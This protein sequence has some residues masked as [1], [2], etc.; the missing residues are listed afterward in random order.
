MPRRSEKALPDVTND[1]F[2]AGLSA[3]A[4]KPKVTEADVSGILVRPCLKK[5]L[6]YDDSQIDAEPS[7]TQRLR[8]DYVC[9]G[10]SLG[11]ELIIEVK[12][13]GTN[14]DKRRSTSY[15]TSPTGQLTNYLQKREDAT[16]F[17]W[18]L[19]TNGKEWRLFRRKGR[20]IEYKGRTTPRTL[21]DL[22]KLLNA[23]L[24]TRPSSPIQIT[25]RDLPRL[26]LPV[27]SWLDELKQ[28]T[29]TPQGFVATV[30]PSGVVGGAIQQSTNTYSHFALAR[31]GTINDQNTL[32]GASVY[33]TA[34]RLNLPDNILAP[35][36]ITEA[37]FDA[38]QVCG[39]VLYGIAWIGQL[40]T[41]QCRGFLFENGTLRTTSSFHPDLPGSRAMHQ[42][43]QFEEYGHEDLDKVRRVLD[44]I[45]LR[46]IF[47]EEIS[48]WFKR[49]KS[50][51][52]ELRHLIRILF[53]WLLQVREII[54]DTALLPNNDVLND[55]GSEIHDHIEW[56][57]TKVLAKA[58]S[59]RLESGRDSDLAETV[60]F[61]NGSLF[62]ELNE[63]DR[64]ESLP[65]RL[66][67]AAGDRPGLLNILQRYDWTLSEQTGYESETAIDPSM[68]GT[69]F[70]R[71]MLTIEGPR[72]ES[73]GNIKMPGGTYYT[74]HDIA[75]EMTADAVSHWL[76]RRIPS[77]PLD[78]IRQL[79]HPAPAQRQWNSLDQSTRSLILEDLGTLTVFDPCCGS[80]AFTVSMLR[81]LHRASVRLL[82]QHQPNTSILDR[83]IERQLYACDIHPLAVL[84]TRL[85]LFIALVDVKTRH[86][87]HR[88]VIRPL[89]NLET[90]F[91]TANTLCIDVGKQASLNDDE[92]DRNL[93]DLR[94]ARELWITAYTNEEKQIS[95]SE[96]A[97]SRRSI[98]KLIK[99]WRPQED[100]A[101]LDLDLTSHTEKVASVDVRKLFV[102]S[103]GWDIIIGNPPYQ[104]PSIVDRDRAKRHGYVSGQANLY[105]LFLEAALEATK[106]DGCITMII[107]HS[108]V[109][110][111]QLVY[112]TTRQR[113][114][115]VSDCIRIRTYDNRPQPVF[116][117]LPWLK[118]NQTSDESRQR[119]TV[120][121]IEKGLSSKVQVFSKGLIRLTSRERSTILQVTKG[122]QEQPKTWRQWTQCPTEATAKLLAVMR[123]FEKRGRLSGKTRK[124]SFPP[125]AMYFISC[126]PEGL[127]NNRNRKPYLLPDDEYYWLW[128]GLYNSHLFHAYWLMLGD[129]FHVTAEEYST[130]KSPIGWLDDSMRHETEKLTKRLMTDSVLNAC[131]TVHSGAGGKKWP[132]VNFHSNSGRKIISDLDRVLI[133]AYGLAVNPLLE[134]LQEMR[135]GSAHNL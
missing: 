60:P 8:P 13:L 117:K 72:I 27:S 4:K 129:A 47:Y 78:Q 39:R 76:H 73:S 128:I 106:D 95:R 14:L 51:R 97:E 62:T 113:I 119:V 30:Y 12:N 107:P 21:A 55:N 45:D 7:G 59:D 67:I 81:T 70:E 66:Y 9:R 104:E 26:Y 11:A 100:I 127:I 44:G 10:D 89:P 17:T 34:L 96:E 20:D 91:V 5:I 36:D 54:P 6:Q 88:G 121:T 23:I 122:G 71:L 68:L 3:L 109:F 41:M 75:D 33:L 50:G 15:K 87:M 31:I 112:Q 63:N 61:L 123:N 38:E 16:H 133:A 105:T 90:R 120:L 126:L 135:I 35:H 79:T 77:T 94:A 1:W 132:N 115:S 108:L 103:D 32:F 93:S 57:F 46:K 42:I 82:N 116:P 69:L 24:A 84:I 134:E 18:G 48:T 43:R 22:E 74:P 130:V 65:N 99:E 19:L 110:R 83:I 56:L 131:K 124:V 85:R 29:I 53:A 25:I 111:R 101:W 80:G 102:A 64:P 58:K 40:K 37:I 28:D 2:V 49:T 92:L 125:T 114:E 118:H 52:N 86:L 98:K